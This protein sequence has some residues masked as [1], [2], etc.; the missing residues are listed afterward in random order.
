MRKKRYQNLQKLAEQRRAAMQAS[1]NAGSGGLDGETA[2]STVAKSH[3]KNNKSGSSTVVQVTAVADTDDLALVSQGKNLNVMYGASPSTI[4]KYS[5]V[6]FPKKRKL[7]KASVIVNVYVSNDCRT[8]GVTQTRTFKE[9]NIEWV[10]PPKVSCLDPMKSG[11]GGKLPQL[12]LSRPQ[13]KFARNKSKAQFADR[14]DI[15][16]DIKKVT[17]LEFAPL[18]KQV[19]VIK[20]DV[21]GNIQRHTFDC[22]SLEAAIACLTIKIRNQ[23]RHTTKCK[24]DVMSRVIC[25]ENIERRNSLLKHL[26]KF[27]YKRFEWLLEKLDLVYHPH[28]ETIIPVTRKGSIIKLTTIYC[29]RIRNGRLEAYKKELDMEKVKFANEKAEL[30]KWIEEEE[31]QLGLIN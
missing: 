15:S 12:D 29:E 23:Q 27:D 26:R 4:D 25:K 8:D 28:P 21:L 31:R 11:D 16:P 3:C 19:Q 1:T 6:I 20:H 24:R 5:R 14:E 22:A 17:S 18:R 2:S 9:V 10:P 30:E 13:F 7:F